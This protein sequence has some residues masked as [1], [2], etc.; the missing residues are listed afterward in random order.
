MIWWSNML[1]TDVFINMSIFDDYGELDITYIET[2]Y[3]TKAL[4]IGVFDNG[5]SNS[6]VAVYESYED[7]AADFTKIDGVLTWYYSV[8]VT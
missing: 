2:F 4:R 3:P 7:Y 8:L 6:Y 1:I 5:L